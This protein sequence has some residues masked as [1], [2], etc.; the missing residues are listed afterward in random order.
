VIHAP[1]RNYRAGAILAVLTVNEDWPGKSLQQ[2]HQLL[3]LEV[4]RGLQTIE[5][6]ADEV[7]SQGFNFQPFTFYSPVTTK[8][9]HGFDTKLFEIVETNAIRLCATIKDTT[10]NL[11]EIFDVGSVMSFEEDVGIRPRLCKD[12]QAE[13]QSEK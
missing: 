10:L 3:H 2:K 9:K 1:A 12:R 4:S 6:E 5:R 11:S 7:H 13:K 8:I